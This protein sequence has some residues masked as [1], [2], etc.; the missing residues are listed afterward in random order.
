MMYLKGP[1]RSIIEDF[2]L[3]L[4]LLWYM[5]IAN[6]NCIQIIKERPQPSKLFEPHENESVR[7]IRHGATSGIA[8]INHIS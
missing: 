3:V 5:A 7:L 1:R 4:P 2:D 8:V 6:K